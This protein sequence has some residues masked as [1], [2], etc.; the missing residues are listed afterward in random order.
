M[1]NVVNRDFCVGKGGKVDKGQK[2][3]AVFGSQKGINITKRA[4]NYSAW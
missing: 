1:R 3:K 2:K 4:E